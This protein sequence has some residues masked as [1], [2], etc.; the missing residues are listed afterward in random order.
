[1]VNVFILYHL[2]IPENQRFS[3]VFRSYKMRMLAK[4]GLIGVCYLFCYQ[5]VVL[6]EM[7]F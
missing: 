1:M 6:P 2:K 7:Q 5:N 4:N 3:S